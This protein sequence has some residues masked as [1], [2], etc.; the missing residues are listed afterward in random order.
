MLINKIKEFSGE[1]K[2]LETKIGEL[3]V[4]EFLLKNPNF[5]IFLESS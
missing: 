1:N 2:T 5:Y 4:T 3:D